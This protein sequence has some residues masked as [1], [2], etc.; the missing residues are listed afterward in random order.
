MLVV[1]KIETVEMS[2]GRSKNY[3]LNFVRTEGAKV[4]CCEGVGD[5][6]PL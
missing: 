5:K 6:G 4:G 1:L 3:S 2:G